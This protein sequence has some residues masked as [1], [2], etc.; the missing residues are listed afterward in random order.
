MSKHAD[1]LNDAL[2]RKKVTVYWEELHHLEDQIANQ[3]ASSSEL[4]AGVCQ[5]VNTAGTSNPEFET[6][7]RGIMR[8]L[9]NYAE[10]YASIREQYKDKAGKIQSPDEYTTYMSHGTNLTSMFEEITTVIGHACFGLTDH[11]NNALQV[12]RDRQ[13]NIEDVQI[14]SE[15][16]AEEPTKEESNV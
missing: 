11:H 14:K 1:D 2:F 3:I 6:I 10:K 4:V 15:T 16:T 13:A 12:L 8:S 9:K 7:T 5:D